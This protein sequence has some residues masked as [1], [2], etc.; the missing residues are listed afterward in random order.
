LRGLCACGGNG[1][2]GCAL[3]ESTTVDGHGL[4][5][6]LQAIFSPFVRTWWD[7]RRNRGHD[8]RDRIRRLAGL[9]ELPA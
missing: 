4:P 3:N 1:N 2:H 9:N 5:P 7:R 8:M 6:L